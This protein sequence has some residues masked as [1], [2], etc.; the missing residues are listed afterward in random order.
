MRILALRDGRTAVP[1]AKT[2][3]VRDEDATTW[4]EAVKAAAEEGVSMS[5]FVIA[6][7]RERLDKRD[8]LVF[9]E[10]SVQSMEPFSAAFMYK[11]TH[12]FRGRWI[13]KDAR[14]NHPGANPND[15]WSIAITEGGFFAVH[16]LRGGDI[17]WLG[18]NSSLAELAN[19]FGIPADVV[20][21]ALDALSKT[22][23]VIRRDI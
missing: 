21:T 19:S 8:P 22:E 6:A 23:W 9:E 18:T 2:L 4:D 1:R 16:V 3:Y 17:P 20:E 10:I 14:S 15:V 12:T 13:L 7:V 11:A 5:E